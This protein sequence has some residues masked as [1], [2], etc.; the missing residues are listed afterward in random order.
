M[1]GNGKWFCAILVMAVLVLTPSMATANTEHLTVPQ[2]QAA[3]SEQAIAPQ[4]H[5]NSI[6]EGLAYDITMTKRLPQKDTR[7]GLCYALI[8]AA[9]IV[10]FG[11]G[12]GKTAMS[13]AV[14]ICNM[15]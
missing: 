8:G 7:S 2:H 3:S 11:G 6:A 5:Q 1:K 12:D 15:G 14:G 10:A 9:W 13:Y 4:V